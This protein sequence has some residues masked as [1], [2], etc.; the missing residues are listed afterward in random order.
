MVAQVP[1]GFTGTF[2]LCYISEPV[3]P[4]CFVVY[5]DLILV[6]GAGACMVVLI[7]VQEQYQG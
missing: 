2:F 3:T 4:F 7:D 1:G 5:F 6:V